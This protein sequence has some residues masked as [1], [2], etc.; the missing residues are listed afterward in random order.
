M[1]MFIK[2][3]HVETAHI[4]LLTSV[5]SVFVR[6]PLGVRRVVSLLLRRD[7]SERV[8]SNIAVTMLILVLWAPTAWLHSKHVS[9]IDINR[10]AIDSWMKTPGLLKNASYS[11]KLKPYLICF[12]QSSS[13][14]A[15]WVQVPDQG[16]CV[17]FLGNTLNSLSA[18][19]QPGV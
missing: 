15:V 11:K 3:P 5:Y 6:A 2:R 16:H 19:L 13:G 12:T 4:Y 8:P 17:V 18:F 1:L 9:V 7:P 10:W 14:H